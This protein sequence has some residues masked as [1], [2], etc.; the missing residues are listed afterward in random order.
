MAATGSRKASGT[1]SSLQ[2]LWV[3]DA[4]NAWAAGAS[5]ALVSW[6]G[7]RWSSQLSG[8]GNTI[9]NLWGTNLT[10]LWAVGSNGMILEKKAALGGS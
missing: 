10:H 1:S 3:A 5:G 4:T 6:N 8:T 7:S 9:S 2:T